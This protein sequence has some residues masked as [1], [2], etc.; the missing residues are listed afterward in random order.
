M[1]K[2]WVVLGII[3]ILLAGCSGAVESPTCDV[4]VSGNQVIVEIDLPAEGMAYRDTHDLT[5][6]GFSGTPSEVTFESGGSEIEYAQTGNTY[7]IAYTVN[8]KQGEI[9]SYQ[10]TISGNV[11]GDE[12]FTCSK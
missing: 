1:R 5:P 12:V 10:I 4:Y 6:A 3:F 8:Y 2:S 7:L 11:Y 9:S